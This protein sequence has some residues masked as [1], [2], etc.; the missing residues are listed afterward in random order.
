[1][2]EKP[3]MHQMTEEEAR[4]YQVEDLREELRFKRQVMILA[5]VGGVLLGVLISVDPIRWLL[6]F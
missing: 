3:D 1:M 5:L 6:E 4:K 2:N